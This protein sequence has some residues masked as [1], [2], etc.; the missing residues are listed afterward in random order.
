MD[1]PLSTVNL[2][3]V[4]SVERCGEFMT[5]LGNRRDVL[6]I[7][8]ESGGLDPLR[9]RLRLV[10][11]GDMAD[12][13]AIPW[14]RWGGVAEEALVKYDG[15]TVEHNAPYDVRVLEA[16]TTK[17]KMNWATT[18]D[19]MTQ[20]HL[21]N[22]NRLKGLKPLSAQEIDQQAARSQRLLADAMVENKW[23]WDTV[24]IDFPYYWIYG[25]MDPV[26]TC[27]LHSKFKPTIDSIYSEPYDIEMASLRILTKMM[28]KGAKVDIGYCHS[29]SDELLAW[30]AIAREWALS[31]FGLDNPGSTVQ[32]GKIFEQL[33]VELLDK[34]TKGGKQSLDKEVLDLV[35]H[36]LGDI[37]VGIRRAEKAVG[38]YL[39]KFIELADEDGRLHANMFSLGTKTARMTVTE[40]ALQT[41]IRKDPT[42]R[43]AFVPSDAD[44][45]LITADYDQ[46]EAR[47]AA[48]FSQ[49][50]GLI[51]AFRLADEEG[52]DFFCTIGSRIYGFDMEKKNPLRQ[53]VKNTVYGKLYAA[54]V[55]KMALTA[56]VPYETM[57]AVNLA[58]DTMYPGINKMQKDVDF[59]SQTQLSERG[60]PYIVT[61]TGRR[62]VAKLDKGY[63]LVNYRI[64]CH[65]AEILKV[66]MAE[67][68]AAGYGDDLILP[69]HDEL[70]FDMPVDKLEAARV[71]IPKIMRNDIDFLVPITAS[72]DV[73]PGNWGDKYRV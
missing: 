30:S 42:V 3:L 15:P 62:M 56:R 22:P 69:V 10:Q 61:P 27:H 9:D 1:S 64:Q 43:T 31:Q 51:E 6:G 66:K 37:V 17:W 58:V 36:P 5:W 4:D 23:T 68:D 41:L 49:D 60:E 14:E 55:K 57:A 72:A 50:P 7:D 65:A 67:L 45:V 63:T 53:L 25:A 39:Q 33:G 21:I 47:L 24:P 54:G 16:N 2:H 26:L 35:D 12:G 32:L 20:A 29:K 38:S 71:D 28:Q 52:S 40:P 59:K 13:W 18:N 48:H 34:R 8:T 70:V 46:I 19:T 44:H 73:L 11:F